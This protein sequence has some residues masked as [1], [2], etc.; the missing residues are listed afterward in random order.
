MKSLLDN[1]EQLGQSKAK[2]ELVKLSS[3]SFQ[4]KKS[5]SED[6]DLQRFKMSIQKQDRA[7]RE[8]LMSPLRVPEVLT[9]EDFRQFTMELVPGSPL[10]E[11][12]RLAG[13]RK[14]ENVAS[15][16]EEYLSSSTYVEQINVSRL[17]EKLQN[18]VAFITSSYS[19]GIC[20]IS[21]EHANIAIEIIGSLEPQSS[22][23]HGDFSMDNLLVVPG[24]LEIFA[25][26]FLDGPMENRVEDFGRIWL[27]IEFG[28]WKN[29]IPSN[30]EIFAR[31]IIRKG[32]KRAALKRNIPDIALDSLALVSALRI[33]PYTKNPSRKATMLSA[34]NELSR[35]LYQK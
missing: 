12:I 16:L 9:V 10:G 27:D 14:L 29:F 13:W 22:V 25:I 33:F 7:W 35:K 31:E 20:L 15:K 21:Q 32:V 2:L 19:R 24:D 30:S 4:V 18:A 26:D 23:S 28:W 6:G 5:L 8:G 17:Y 11:F 34:I 3:S 1:L